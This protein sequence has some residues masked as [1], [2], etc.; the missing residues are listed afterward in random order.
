MKK[1][2][3]LFLFPKFCFALQEKPWFGD[4]L[5]LHF[6][7]LYDYNFFNKVSHAVPSQKETFHTHVL[8]LGLDTTALET[9]N[10]GA[11]LE[12][13]DTTSAPFGYRSLALQVR[14]LWLDDVG[15]DPVSLSTGF[16]YRNASK[17][18][19][20]AL[21]TPYHANGNFEVH[22][23]IGKEWSE[24]LY[25]KFRTYGTLAI[26][27]GTE[28]APW[29]R[30]DLFLGGNVKDHHQFWLFANSYWGL[31]KKKTVFI[32][33]FNGWSRIGHQSIDVGGNYRYRLGVYGWLSVEYVH[34]VYARSYPEHVNFFILS[35]DFPFAIF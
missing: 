5:E 4:F 2:L 14:K 23:A 13:A 1:L 7:P 17:K 28:G 21:S 6:R 25:W 30:G 19:R 11:E 16:V 22:T 24:G 9:W 15:G 29:L 31:G 3:F 26:G 32:D 35:L 34:R 10:F 33:K 27:Q 20:K 8:S 18:M 12:C